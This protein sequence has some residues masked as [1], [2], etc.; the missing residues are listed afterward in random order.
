MI[1]FAGPATL[2]RNQLFYKRRQAPQPSTWLPITPPRIPVALAAT[3][4][5]AFCAPR[6]N[7]SSWH[8]RWPGW[9]RR[10][11]QSLARA[12]CPLASYLRGRRNLR[13]LPFRAYHRQQRPE[14]VYGPKCPGCVQRLPPGFETRGRLKRLSQ[15]FH[16]SEGSLILLGEP[17]QENQNPP[18][19]PRVGR[20]FCL[21]W[22]Q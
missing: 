10:R 16:Q 8:P 12:A 5:G 22:H 3:P 13:Q 20:I 18:D 1:H 15:W 21:L 17:A 11:K 9:K 2:S 4:G 7:H 6:A 19:A 14:R